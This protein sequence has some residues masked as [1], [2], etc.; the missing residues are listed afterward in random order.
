MTRKTIILAMP[1]LYGLDECVARNLRYHGYDVINLCHGKR[2]THYPNLFSRVK[3]WY[4]KKIKGDQDYQK[5]LHYYL[6]ET[7]IA[8]Q[9]SPFKN[10]PADY[11]LCIRANIYPKKIVQQIR[12]HSQICVNYQWDGIDRYPDILEYV[13]YF[14]RFFVF[15][16]SDVAKYPQYDFQAACNFYFDDEL[17][18]H[19]QNNG[20]LYFV[21]GYEYSRTDSIRQFIEYAQKQGWSLDFTLV[22][23]HPERVAHEIAGQGIRHLNMENAPSFTENIKKAQQSSVLV[24]FVIQQHQGLSFRTFEALGYRKKL[25]TTNPEVARY[26]FYHPHNIHIWDGQ[27]LDGIREF[28]ALPYHE[29][30]PHIY[31]KYRFGNWIRHILNIEPHHKIN[32][33][34]TQR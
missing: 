20:N 32:L 15:D 26:D 21:G 9:L 17:S 4:C 10:Q 16:P 5:Q 23:K 8:Q 29:L 11:A 24:D 12:E 19:Q 33:P 27:N 34:N 6:Y 28:L 22:S 7:Q 14:D 18:Q 13:G 2:K 25:I 31:E 1:F 30:P 3:N